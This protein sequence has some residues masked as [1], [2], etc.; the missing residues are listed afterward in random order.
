MRL[1]FLFTGIVCI[2]TLFGCKKQTDTLPLSSA[3]SYLPLQTGKRFIYRLDS[4]VYLSF[5]SASRVISYLAKD[6]IVSTFADNTGRTSYTVYRYTTDTLQQ[7]PWQYKSAYYI[8]P[9]AH[10]AEV[11]DDNNFRFI[12]LAEPITEG[13]TWKGNSYLDTRSDASAVQYLYNWEYVYQNVG[14]PYQLLDATFE[15]TITVLQQDNTFPE[16]DFDP[17]FYQQRNY[18]VEVYAKDIGLIYK[19]FLH[20]TWQTDPPPAHYEDGSYGIRLSLIDHN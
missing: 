18:S 17:Q 10:S 15:N 7:S 4:T 12:K 16:G 13:Y 19:D 8:T 1:S 14:M 6:S 20:W 11:V 3:A 2:S 9:T 5:G